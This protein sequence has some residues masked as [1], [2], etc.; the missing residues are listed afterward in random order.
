LALAPV[1]GKKSEKGKFAGAFYTT[2]GEVILPGGKA[3]QVCTS[4]NLGTNF[5]KAFKIRF[6]GIDGKLHWAYQ[7]SWGLSWRVL[8]AMI[9]THGDAKG[10]V[11]PPEIAPVQVIIIP[12]RGDGKDNEIMETVESLKTKLEGLR[13]KIDKTEMRPGAAFNYYEAKGI[14][15]RIEIGARDMQNQQITI[16]NRV[17]GERETLPVGFPTTEIQKRLDSIQSLLLNR[18]QDLVKKN[19][20][21]VSNWGEF[22]KGISGSVGFLSTYHC[23]GRICEQEIQ[24][25]TRA[26]LRCIPFGYEKTEGVCVKCGKPSGYGQK[27]LF[28]KA[29]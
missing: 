3:L 10:L 27:V 7:T 6:L 4:H 21:D 15:L 8:G 24:D 13:V 9:M 22:K 19:T 12:I 29:Y 14:P 1:I 23:G 25:K 11:F 18:A 2:T 16:A 5:S 26:T 20:Q 28:A 17:T